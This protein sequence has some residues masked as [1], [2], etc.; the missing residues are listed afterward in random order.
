M[1]KKILLGLILSLVLTG[2][3]VANKE[4]KELKNALNEYVNSEVNEY[5]YEVKVENNIMTVKYNEQDYTITYDL[6][7]NP[8]FVYEVEVKKGIDYEEYFTKTEGFTLPKIGYIALANTYG[9][10]FEDSSVYFDNKYL[11]GIFNSIPEAA[12]TYIIVDNK[13]DYE[14]EGI[15]ILTK[16][17]GD[18]VVEYVESSYK[19]DT[20]FKD[21]D[22]NTFSYNLSAEC[23]KD[24][25]TITSKLTVNK[26]GNFSELKGYSD[27]LAKENM[28]EN[29]TPE[30]ADYHIEL[31]VG[32]VIAIKGKNLTGY[33]IAGID[34]VEIE[35]LDSEYIFS[36]IKKGVANGVFYVGE[37]DTRTFYLTVTKATDADNENKTLTVK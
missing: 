6:S 15:V 23:E 10:D 28:D 25:C 34:V 4:T 21:E 22:N 19:N 35:S 29:I 20:S 5:G 18:K 33:E 13:E 9:V 7:D 14:G 16:D 31:S 3:G 2:C 30:S 26:D 11:D 37:E 24:S 1:K 12:E 17:F 36:A 27:E 8:T 32:D